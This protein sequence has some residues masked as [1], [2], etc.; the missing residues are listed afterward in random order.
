M[1]EKKVGGMEGKGR[2]GKGR[3]GKGE[4][5]EGRGRWALHIKQMCV[6]TYMHIIQIC[7]GKRHSVLK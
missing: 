2:E 3:E 1:G 5:R 7:A 4:R 6:L